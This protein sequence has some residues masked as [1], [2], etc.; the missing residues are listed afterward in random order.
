M[1]VYS[2]HN[3]CCWHGFCIIPKPRNC[4]IVTPKPRNCTTVIPKPRNSTT[5]I[6]KPRNCTTV[7]PKPRNCT[8]VLSKPRNCTTVY[9]RCHTCDNPL[10]LVFCNTGWMGSPPRQL[11]HSLWFAMC[12]ARLVYATFCVAI[13]TS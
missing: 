8:T 5:V 3:C 13:W 10:R 12:V 7:I 1:C 6:P 11:S 4:T 2:T 9:L